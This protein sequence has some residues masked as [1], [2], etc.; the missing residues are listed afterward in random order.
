MANKKL[1]NSVEIQVALGAVVS[2]LMLISI[3]CLSFV[4]TRQLVVTEKWVAHTHEVIATLESGLALLTDAET[5]MRGYLLTGD[6]QYL[7]EC[8][9]AQ[10]QIAGWSKQI[11]WLTADN[12]EAQHQL[13]V[14]D[15]MIQQRLTLINSRIQLRQ[16]LGLRSEAENLEG[17]R[18]GR[19]LM[20]QIWQK[21]GEMRA[22]EE[23]LLQERQDA[24][25]ASARFCQIMIVS[26]STLACVVV[27]IAFLLVRRGLRLRARAEEE[28]KGS[29]ALMESILDNIPA[30]VFIKDLSGRY[31]F[32]NRRFVEVAG[33]PREEIQGKTAF[34]ITGREL[35]QQAERHFQTV[36]KT[37][38]PIEIEEKVWHADGIHPHLAVKFPVRDA[39]GEIW[40]MAGISTDITERKKM[41]RMQLQFQSIFES[42]PGLYIVLK[43]DL[44][45]MAASDAYLKATMTKREQ[46]IGRGIFEVFPDDPENPGADGVAN[47]RASLKR[48]LKN[49]ATD[50]MAVQRFDIRRPDGV[51]EERYW[52]TINSPILADDGGVEFM[53]HRVEDVTE[54]IRRQSA[55]GKAGGGEIDRLGQMEAEIFRSSQEVKTINEQLRTANQELEA[56]SYS[57]SHDLRA[58]LRHIDGFVGLLRKQT[59]SKL[60]E[61]ELRYLNVIANSARQMGSLIDDLLVFSRMSRM[62]LRRSNVALNSLVD[63]VVRAAQGEAQGRSIRWQIP[64]LPEVEADPPMLRQVWVNLIS[65]AVKYTRTRN[66]AEIEVGCQDGPDNEWTF[67]VR[68]NGVGFDMQYVDKLFGVF[69]RLHRTDEFEGTGIGLA[70]VRRI[71]FRHGGQTWAEGKPDG[72]ATFYFS[73]PKQK[74][75]RQ[76][77]YGTIKTDTAG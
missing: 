40:A 72:G 32:V 37:E 20:D 70:N 14:L 15:L 12:S 53:I 50:T 16:E 5:T 43:P 10:N 26:G 19:S 52:S 57:V 13:D 54:F 18:L 77:N 65:N 45:I 46:I 51:F 33:K 34:D 11:R 6:D 9:A 44:T 47:L 38:K 66:P 36:M 67:F 31:L 27:I 73:L 23:Q 42:A 17:L 63:E 8:Q 24:A 35:A 75:K 28:L 4:N 3:G 56:F 25:Q 2:V 22:R 76:D 1:R 58:P 29:Q 21:V 60:E 39:V 59:T 61:K 74:K 69:Q 7:Q 48:V 49:G 64:S 55:L 62:E 30:M 41:E 71:I 68:D